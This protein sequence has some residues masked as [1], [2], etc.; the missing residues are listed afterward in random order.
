MTPSWWARTPALRTDA[1][2]ARP[3]RRG[4]VFIHD[5]VIPWRDETL[6][7]AL[8]RAEEDGDQAS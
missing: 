8:L 7:L 3:R 1:K 4:P 5:T 6:L 2:T